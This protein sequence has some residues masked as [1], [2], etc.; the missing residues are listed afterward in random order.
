M[1]RLLLLPII[2]FSCIQIAAS[3]NLQTTIPSKEGRTFIIPPGPTYVIDNAHTEAVYVEIQGTA[4]DPAHAIIQ[5]GTEETLIYARTIYFQPNLD[6]FRL[7][8]GA[9]I[10]QAGSILNGPKRIEFTSADNVMVLE[11]F[12]DRPAGYEYITESGI[13]VVSDGEEIHLIFTGNEEGDRVLKTVKMIRGH[14]GSRMLPRSK[15]NEKTLP[16]KTSSPN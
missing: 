14:Q 3:Q 12:P 13:P 9:R 15:A 8:G 5:D 11:G 7:T 2:A 6:N 16:R 4:S 10:E 1:N